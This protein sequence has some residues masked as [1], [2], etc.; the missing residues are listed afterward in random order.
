V[1]ASE[2]SASEPAARPVTASMATNATSRQTLRQGA[3]EGGGVLVCVVAGHD[4]LSFAGPGGWAPDARV[5]RGAC[6]PRRPVGEEVL[7][8]SEL[9]RVTRAI[10]TRSSQCSRRL[11]APGRGERQ[12]ARCG[13]VAARQVRAALSLLSSRTGAGENRALPGR[14]P[15][16]T[17]AGASGCV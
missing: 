11:P 4:P 8:A 7:L 13:C 6:P 3:P 16:S 1:S 10:A 14:C 12:G 17:P 2:T 5:A 15:V 9:V